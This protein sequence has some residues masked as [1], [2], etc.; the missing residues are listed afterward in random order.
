MRVALRFWVVLA[1]AAISA[2]AES[3]L[4]KNGFTIAVDRHETEGDVVHLFLPG[5][6]TAD[7]STGDIDRFITDAPATEPAKAAPAPSATPDP[8]PATKPDALHVTLDDLIR[9]SS[10]RH[11]LD[12]VLIRCMIAAESAGSVRAVSPKGA[13]GLMQLMPATARE[14]GVSNVFD[15]PANV[16][17][18]TAYIRQLLD[19]YGHDLALALAAYN[20]GPGTVQTYK[21]LPPYRET[22]AYVRRII[23]QFN[24]EKL[25]GN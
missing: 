23:T 9:V 18:G 10:A 13:S 19:K 5:G 2:S 8:K 4:L 3:A 6:G 25:K 14:L 15:A 7:M 21:G 11:G 20:A 22:D 1:L 16:E 17:A 24:R 12:P